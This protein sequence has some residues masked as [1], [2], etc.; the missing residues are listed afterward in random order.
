MRIDFHGLILETPG[1]SIY[2]WTPWRASALEHRLF[3][4]VRQVIHGTPE[5]QP[6]ELRLD[7]EEPKQWRA[8]VQ[9]M[10]RVLKGWQEDGDP[11]RE[12]RAFR[13]LLEGDS[14][15]NGYDVLGEPVSLWLFLSVSLERG[16]PGEPER[17]EEIEL[18]GIGVRIW[19]EH[20]DN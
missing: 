16:E 8:A 20:G 15:A 7:I 19:G 1:I 9:A 5:E 12:R 13:W 17:A 6:D 11:G 2:L 10:V 14:D 4:A 18:E 3:D